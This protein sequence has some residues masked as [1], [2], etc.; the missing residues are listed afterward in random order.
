MKLFILNKFYNLNNV[1]NGIDIRSNDVSYVMLNYN[2]DSLTGFNIPNTNINDIYLNKHI[3]FS[4]SKKRIFFLKD[5]NNQFVIISK[6]FWNDINNTES[7]SMLLPILKNDNDLGWSNFERRK[8]IKILVEDSF[9]D[10]LVSSVSANVN[11]IE[12]INNIGFSL[13]QGN[14]N[15]ENFKLAYISNN[16]SL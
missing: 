11:S 14:I 6:D 8:I 12:D 16:P 5:Y 10:P 2:M 3:G 15:S 1:N 13:L 7:Q 9:F 4:A